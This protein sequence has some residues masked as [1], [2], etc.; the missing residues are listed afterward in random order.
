MNKQEALEVFNGIMLGDA[1]L[2]L[3]GRNG[4][5]A[6]L[7]IALSAKR[8]IKL[9]EQTL[10]YLCSVRDDLLF[11]GINFCIG[12][13]VVSDRTSKGK[14]YRNCK[15]SSIVCPFLKDEYHRWYPGG[16]R[17]AK[18]VA[19]GQFGSQIVVKE[20]PGEKK[21]VPVNITL[22]PLSLAHWFMGDGCSQQSKLCETVVVNLSTYAFS[23][24]DIEILERGLHDL[25]IS[26]GRA[27][28]P[29]INKGS[30]VRLTILQNSVNDFMHMIDPYVVEP[31]RY[32]IKYRTN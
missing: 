21:V 26:T 6:V 27:V 4:T 24:G 15:L 32:K 1:G 5:G 8:D 29:S 30:G 3:S 23:F 12:H 14:L 9:E 2:G 25:N 7:N 18:A 19:R 13:P 17:V 28:Y 22:T 11:L 31:Y 10:A 16:K 20:Y